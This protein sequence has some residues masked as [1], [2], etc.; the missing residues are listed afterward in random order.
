MV[1]QLC[2]TGHYGSILCC[3]D[4][5][6]NEKK[7]LKSMSRTLNGPHSNQNADSLKTLTR[8]LCPFKLSCSHKY[9]AEWVKKCMVECMSECDFI[10]VLIP[11]QI[12]PRIFSMQWSKLSTLSTRKDRILAHCDRRHF[13]MIRLPI[14]W[15]RTWADDKIW[16]NWTNKQLI[17]WGHYESCDVVEKELWKSSCD[18]MH[19]QQGKCYIYSW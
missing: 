2:S 11:H 13:A 10:Q 7:N 8:Q 15:F 4:I 5:L 16:G 14:A 17:R 3:K 1:I 12:L 6:S 9:V 19:W 18:D